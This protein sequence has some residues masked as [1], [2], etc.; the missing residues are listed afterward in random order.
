[1]K[2][3]SNLKLMYPPSDGHDAINKKYLDEKISVDTELSETSEKP[4]QNKVITKELAEL[5]KSVSD[6]KK[7]VAD[8][9]TEQ[10]IKTAAD[11][12]FQSMHDNILLISGTGS[13]LPN[14]TLGN[15]ASNID[16][17]NQLIHE[18]YEKGLPFL[19]YDFYGGYAVVFEGKIH[20]LG[21]YGN[22]DGH[23]Y[24]EDDKNSANYNTWVQASTLPFHFYCGGCVVFQN[25]IHIF[26][27]ANNTGMTSW[28]NL[29]YSYPHETIVTTTDPA[30]GETIQQTAM[31]WKEEA[32]VLQHAKACFG[33]TCD[34]ENIYIIGG[35]YDTTSSNITN[36]RTF[37][38]MHY[39]TDPVTGEKSMVSEILPN[40]PVA[41]RNLQAKISSFDGNLYVFGGNNTSGSSGSN[42]KTLYKYYINECTDINGNQLQNT[43]ESIKP[44]DNTTN[45][46][47]STL[48]YWYSRLNGEIYEYN[49]KFLITGNQYILSYDVKSNTVETMI[50]NKNL[51][52]LYGQMIF[53]KNETY[54]LGAAHAYAANN[55]QFCKYNFQNGFVSDLQ[56]LNP[57]SL[58]RSTCAYYHGK[59]HVFGTAAQYQSAFPFANSHL[60]FDCNKNKWELA[61]EIPPSIQIRDSAAVVYQDKIY[62]IGG[63]ASPTVYCTWDETH[64]YSSTEVISDLA[65][66][67]FESSYNGNSTIVHNNKLHILGSNGKDKKIHIIYDE[68]NNIWEEYK[69]DSGTA[70]KMPYNFSYGAALSYKGTIHI[71][72]GS[73][74]GNGHYF[75]DEDVSSPTYQTWV[76]LPDIN[77]NSVT[78]AACYEINGNLYVHAGNFIN[79][80]SS[81]SGSDT[82]TQQFNLGQTSAAMTICKND[83]TN[84]VY[85]FNNNDFAYKYKITDYATILSTGKICI[86]NNHQI[87]NANHETI[88][89]Y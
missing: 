6:G 68:E 42:Q 3:L 79:K 30:T 53:Y 57:L 60:T 23:Y 17:T 40:M 74:D 76:K 80:F 81:N 25:K 36:Y 11:A 13:P 89:E 12:T 50:R 32:A 10:G 2:V 39:T 45:N 65:G 52:L 14:V 48:T 33:F 71:F 77:G 7:L 67:T 72:S 88:I 22:L 24:Y 8:A 31:V 59:I 61:D 47:F 44:I 55:N 87:V 41:R 78:G 86:A 38:K 34:D 21:G 64:G 51:P 35:M 43:W 75:L 4:V 5:K 62:L 27:G 1:M 63:S 28:K 56:C 26:G 46:Y 54:I 37:Q 66:T 19:P 83:D 73:G 9:I 49:G 58:V 84:E 82:F 15:H 29:H 16:I 18:G 69:N 20:I 70:V 85:I